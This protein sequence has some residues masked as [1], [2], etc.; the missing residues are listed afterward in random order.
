MSTS[1]SSTSPLA[2]RSR[3]T[4]PPAG[5]GVDDELRPRRARRGARPRPGS[6]A[7]LPLISARPPSALR[8][9]IVQSAPSLPGRIVI[10]PSAPTPRWRSHKRG[11]TPGPDVAARGPTRASRSTHEEVVA[12]GV[13]L[14]RCSGSRSSATRSVHVARSAGRTGERIPV[15]AEPRDA[16]I[17]AEPHPLAPGEAPGALGGRRRAPRR[18]RRS[19]PSRWARTSLYPIAWRAVR[20]SPPGRRPAAGPRRPARRRACAANALA[21]SGARA[22]AGGS[23][24]RRSRTANA[25][26]RTPRS[27]GPND[28]NGRPVTSITSSAAHDAARG[29]RARSARPPPGR[30][31]ASSA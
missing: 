14:G 6:A 12:G 5:G 25:G 21:R 24:S 13:E 22:P 31:R 23:H 9:S 8:R 7:P 17:A 15:R 3:S 19:R 10:S 30:A 20:D 28:E 1:A 2:R 4:L 16:R 26:G 11:T 27:P 18:G 29:C